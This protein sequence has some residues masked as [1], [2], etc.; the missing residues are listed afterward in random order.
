MVK[1]QARTTIKLD[2]ATKKA[3]LPTLSTIMP[4]KGA[5]P[6]EIKKG[7]LYK[8]LAIFL[9]TLNSFKSIGAVF[10]E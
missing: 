1:I 9:G 3:R 6:A 4:R 5:I 10:Q 7:K 2:K 8:A